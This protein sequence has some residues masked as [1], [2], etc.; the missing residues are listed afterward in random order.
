MSVQQDTWAISRLRPDPRNKDLF[1]DLPVAEAND[2]RESVV[3]VG[4]INPITVTPTGLIICGH[5]RYNA[6]KAAGIKFVTVTVRPIPDDDIKALMK[7]RIEEQF[8]RRVLPTMEAARVVW[9]WHELFGI[10]KGSEGNNHADEEAR[11]ELERQSG[12]SAKRQAMYISLQNLTDEWQS[13]V[14]ARGN[15]GL[16]LAYE[17]SQMTPEAQKTYFDSL[18]EEELENLTREAFRTYKRE[19][20]AEEERANAAEAERDELRKELGESEEGK[21]TLDLVDEARKALEA[22]HAERL[23][24]LAREMDEANTAHTAQMEELRRVASK[25]DEEAQRQIK[26]LTAKTGTQERMRVWEKYDVVHRLFAAAVSAM[27]VVPEEW[28][29]AMSDKAEV[30]PFVASDTQTAE[31]LLHWLTRFL[32][33]RKGVTGEGDT[34]RRVK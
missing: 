20:K 34:L 1:D 32:D 4:Q 18:S 21:K 7:L 29:E 2:L 25:K 10:K 23:A 13:Y 19:L 16:T 24:E 8:R 31:L 9:D 17:I 14:S 3:E 6:M 22:T 15:V 5:Q 11:K 28:V 30:A 12:I 33:A 27:I 26:I